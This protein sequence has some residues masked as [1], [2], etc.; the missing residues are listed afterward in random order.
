MSSP[1]RPELTPAEQLIWAAGFLDG[2]GSFFHQKW[3]IGCVVTATQTER[4]PLELLLASYG[5]SIQLEPPRAGRHGG[6]IRR[7]R[8]SGT[9]ARRLMEEILPLV[10]PKRQ[11]QILSALD[12]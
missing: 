3:N 8:V 5:G 9:R 12:K 11:N 2:E 6:E 7:W 4:W 10:S 1:Q